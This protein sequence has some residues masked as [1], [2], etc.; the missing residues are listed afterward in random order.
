MH[1]V[2]GGGGELII[3]GLPTLEIDSP[4]LAHSEIDSL[5]CYCY[6]HAHLFTSYFKFLSIPRL[7]KISCIICNANAKDLDH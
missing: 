6:I 3:I 4:R 2:M 7:W 5:L 1:I